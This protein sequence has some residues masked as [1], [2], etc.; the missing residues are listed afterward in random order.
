MSEQ[1]ER[2]ILEL[3]D[4]VEVSPFGNP[5]PGLEHLGRGQS[6]AM[7]EKVIP[8]IELLD[9]DVIVKRIAEP[10]QVYSDALAHLAA[11]HVLP[12]ARI[13]ASQASD[14]VQV[15]SLDGQYS[16]SLTA[17][18]VAHIFVIPA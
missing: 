2:K 18:D 4:E 17:F 11:A 6:T 5:I 16:V 7:G 13:R 1:V 12:G 15:S 3:V 10:L 9:T 8:L 14:R